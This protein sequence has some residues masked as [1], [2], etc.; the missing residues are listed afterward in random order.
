MPRI[1]VSAD[2]DTAKEYADLIK[3][4][5]RLYHDVNILPVLEIERGRASPN[6]GGQPRIWRNL[7]SV[8]GNNHRLALH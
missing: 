5:S 7:F 2:P 6:A 8:M 3:R 1:D 4:D